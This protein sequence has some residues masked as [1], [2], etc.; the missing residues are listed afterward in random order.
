M[1]RRKK[2]NKQGIWYA[3]AGEGY[4]VPRMRSTAG[5][6]AQRYA[7]EAQHAKERERI[8]VRPELSPL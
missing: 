6:E 4:G 5:E 1:S 2:V 3:D 7:A 8:K